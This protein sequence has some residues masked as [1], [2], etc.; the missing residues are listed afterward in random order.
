L[1]GRR[2]VLEW[3]KEEEDIEQLREKTRDQFRLIID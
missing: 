2:L 1:Y 3:A